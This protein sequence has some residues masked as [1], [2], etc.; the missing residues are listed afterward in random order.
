MG[1]DNHADVKTE[2]SELR[3]NETAPKRCVI[4]H[5]YIYN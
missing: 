2:T 4:T 5:H 3:S 1:Y